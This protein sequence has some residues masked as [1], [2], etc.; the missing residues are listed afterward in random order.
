MN[1]IKQLRNDLGLTNKQ[2]AA[3]LGVS[4][5]SVEAY[6]SGHRDIERANLAARQNYEKL[7]KSLR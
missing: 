2:L 1:A 6:I 5:K 7:K 4:I 3:K